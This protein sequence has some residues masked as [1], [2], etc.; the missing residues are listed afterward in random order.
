MC[1]EAPEAALL[2]PAV[3]AMLDEYRARNA[4]RPNDWGD[5]AEGVARGQAYARWLGSQLLVAVFAGQDDNW[6]DTVRGSLPDPLPAGLIVASLRTDGA[7]LRSGPPPYAVPGGAVEVAVLLDSQLDE[8]T[9]IQVD[10]SPARVAAG[11]VELITLTGPGGRTVSVGP[12]T[13]PAGETAPPA[14]LRLRADGP[15]R[16]SVIDDH[17]GAWFPKGRLARW[18]Y[19]DRPMFHGND[20]VVDVPAVPLTITCARGI[21]FDTA[22]ATVTPQAGATTDVDLEPARRYEPA[23]RGWYGGD[24]HVHMNYSG[25]IVCQ[26]HDAACMQLGEGLHLM[27]LVAANVQRTRVYDREAFEG[28]VGSDLPWTTDDRVARFGVEFRN[29][30]LGHFHALGPSRRPTRY[31]TGHAMSNHPVDWPPNSAA[32]EEFQEL[33]ATVGYTHPVFSPL[34]DGSAT[35]A[36]RHP[37]SVEARELVADAALGLVDS[38]DLI[39]P[40]DVEGTAVLYHHLLNCGLRLAATVGTDVWLSYSRGPPI[41]NPPGWARVYA[42]L[43]GAP[44]SVAA[45]QEAIRAGRTLATNGPWLELTVDGRGPGDVLQVEP[46]QMLSVSAR[47]EGPGVERLELIG[48]DGVVARS[49]IGGT[50]APAIDITAEPAGSMWLCAVARGPQHPSVL[51][52]VVFAHTSP[53]YVEVRGQPAGRAASARWLLDWLDRFEQLVRT[54]GQFADGA[55]R[56]QVIDVIERARPYYHA[57]AT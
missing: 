34:T 19:H 23:A 49:V 54:H 25:D 43:R 56:D 46:G 48:P 20:L 2:P 12:A 1:C 28:T 26:P 36:F 38:I 39:G 5:E 29:D 40:N 27:N 11:G 9:Q 45:F 52:P 22:E 13:T 24:L 17:G 47:T 37:R 3:A 16:W 44:L 10:G 50:P 35:E 14:R 8:A 53:V 57:R 4:E 30:L 55:Q 18:D 33:G 31:S 21:E 32:C 15:S 41:S 7:A 6:P 51:G 42:D